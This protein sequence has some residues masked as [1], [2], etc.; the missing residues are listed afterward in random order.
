MLAG[1]PVTVNQ[2][3]Q[4]YNKPTNACL[5]ILREHLPSNNYV[6]T[7]E[8]KIV[9]MEQIESSC[10][11][12]GTINI[13]QNFLKCEEC[14]RDLCWDHFEEISAVGR[15]ICPYCDGSLEFLPKYCEKCHIDYIRVTKSNETCEFC[16]Y[17]LTIK[18]S[19]NS[20]YRKYLGAQQ[21]PIEIKRAAA[22]F[23]KETKT[24]K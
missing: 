18:D 23:S 19:L 16:G 15:P 11:V 13:I 3:K 22:D 2:I 17:P 24:N 12:C 9:Q 8:K 21:K 7:R 20:Y 6:L 5:A 10:Q 14:G 1:Q 4:T